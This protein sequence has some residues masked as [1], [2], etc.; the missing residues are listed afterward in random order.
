MSGIYT[1]QFN[2]VTVTAAQDLF[3]ITGSSTQPLVILGWE[4]GQTSDVGDAQ[5]EILSLLFKSGQTTS[6][7]GGSSPSKV[8]TDGTSAAAGFSAEANNTTKASAGTILTHWAG[9]W[10]VRMAHEKVFTP[11]QQ[12]LLP[13]G[14][15]CTLELVGAPADALTVNGTIWVQ[16]VG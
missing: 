5:E 4:I 8:A 16:E 14:R 13:A 12:I 1:V 11:E 9:T 15:R 7:S 10:N 6:G 3:E 2:A